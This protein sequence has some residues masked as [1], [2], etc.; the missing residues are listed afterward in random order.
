VR[1]LCDQ[2]LPAWGEHPG[3]VATAIDERVLEDLRQLSRG[4]R[5]PNLVAAMREIRFLDLSG[6]QR[7]E[8]L[9]RLINSRDEA[10]I[11]RTLQFV[12]NQSVTYYFSHPD[13]W[14]ALDYRQP[15]PLGYPDYATCSE[16]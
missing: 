4:E 12:L 15:Q 6:D 13:S 2:L 10:G 14:R 11:S 8:A 7:D 5:M 9:R 16:R 1:A 3:A